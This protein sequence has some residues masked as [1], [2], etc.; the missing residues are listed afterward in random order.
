MYRSDKE[1][2]VWTRD[3]YDD[4]E[5]KL[6]YF[7][8]LFTGDGFTNINKNSYDIYM[9]IGKDEKDLASFYDKLVEELFDRKCIRVH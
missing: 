6:A 7:Y 2:Y 3:R 1:K 9:S 4:R 5:R 8:G